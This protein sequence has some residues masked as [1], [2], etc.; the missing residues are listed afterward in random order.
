M[1]VANDERSWWERLGFR[2][3][4]PADPDNLDPCLLTGEIEATLR[5]LE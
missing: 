3:F 2:P 1:P 4:D 5:S